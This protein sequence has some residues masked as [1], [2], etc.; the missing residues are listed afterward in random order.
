M[1]GHS[2]FL[3][4][5]PISWQHCFAKHDNALL[6]HSQHSNGATS[7]PNLFPPVMF[8]QATLP[9]Q[10][11]TSLSVT[12]LSHNIS[13]SNIA[14]LQHN[15]YPQCLPMTSPPTTLLFY[16][17]TSH[18]VAQPIYFPALLPS[19]HISFC[20]ILFVH[21]LSLRKSNQ[22]THEKCQLKSYQ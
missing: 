13:S 8:P 16:G 21:K 14:I 19:Q 11:M 20:N 10:S 17:S 22:K 1:K 9:F 12:S 6:W 18:L 15:V 3:Q 4:L 2:T 7:P 5:N